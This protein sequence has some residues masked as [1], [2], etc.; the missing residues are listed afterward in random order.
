MLTIVLSVLLRYTDFDCP[1]GIFKLFL[2][3]FIKCSASCLGKI[4]LNLFIK[5]TTYCLFK[6]ALLWLVRCISVY[7]SIQE[8]YVLPRNACTFVCFY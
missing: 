4:A 6:I 5:C 3:L 1:F 8:Q 7:L 2:Y